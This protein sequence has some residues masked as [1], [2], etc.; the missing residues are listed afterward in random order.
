MSQ[1]SIKQLSGKLKLGLFGQEFI[2]FF[3]VFYLGI[4][5]AFILS[6]ISEIARTTYVPE[7][8]FGKLILYFLTA[9]LII[10]FLIKIKKGK[11]LL[12]VF[13]IL[14]LFAGLQ[15]VFNLWLNSLFAAVAAVA[16]LIFRSYYPRIWVH[17]VI[18]IL[19]LG[20]IGGV[21]GL[22]V[23]PWTAALILV[24]LSF[25]DIIAVFGTKH[26]VTM[27]KGLLE[28][29]IIIAF[30]IPENLD[31]WREDPS[32]VKPGEKFI[33]M[34]GGDFAL[35]LVLIASMVN[36]NIFASLIIAGFALLGVLLTHLFFIYPKK[37]RPIPALPPI[38]LLSILGFF[39]SFFIF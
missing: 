9:T 35:P 1:G 30:L 39:I 22:A 11:R 4:Y 5:S 27:A 26:M 6:K 12:S 34:G 24:I 33:I 16:V 3:L 31:G 13:F 17:N 21:F 25:Y 7:L 14:A 20:A 18:M 36:Y 10:L 29:G 2:L 37:R 28:R 23:D 19:V 32:Q 15:T 8:D 38:A